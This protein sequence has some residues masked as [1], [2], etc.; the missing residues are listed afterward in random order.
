MC[1]GVLHL[2]NNDIIHRDIKCMNLLL[3]NHPNQIPLIGSPTK[4]TS[5]NPDPA[6]QI[7]KLGDMSESRVLGH[8]S[9]IKTN[10]LIG[11]PQSLAPEVIKN[12]NYD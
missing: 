7:L 12:E 6:P 5:N 4:S 9:Y 10:K 2:H 8:Q 3:S 11:T 1:M